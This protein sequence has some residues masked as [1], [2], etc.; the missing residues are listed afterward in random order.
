MRVADIE[1]GLRANLGNLKNA[2]KGKLPVI[3]DDGER[4][5]GSLFNLQHL[6]VSNLLA[7]SFDENFSRCVGH[8]RWVAAH[9][10]PVVM[11]A[12]FD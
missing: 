10:W 3:E 5:A 12:F 2:A 1:F 9:R 8:S 6:T 11:R 4:L 7:V